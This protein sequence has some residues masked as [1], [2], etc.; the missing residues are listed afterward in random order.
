MLNKQSYKYNV[1]INYIVIV[2]L[3]V[4]FLTILKYLNNLIPN[5]YGFSIFELYYI[6]AC[7]IVIKLPWKI[8]LMTLF[9]SPIF[10]FFLGQTS[11]R[12]LTSFFLDYS[13]PMLCPMLLFFVQKNKSI[14]IYFQII[15]LVIISGL[16]KWLLHTVSG[17]FNYQVPFLTSMIINAPSVIVTIHIAIFTC[18]F[19]LY[20]LPYNSNF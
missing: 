20:K 2:G 11:I 17:Y 1:S 5:F 9:I 4:S 13:F 8:S 18:I 3:L 16:I 6:G 19:V 12:G 15:L 7:V 14:I 10:W